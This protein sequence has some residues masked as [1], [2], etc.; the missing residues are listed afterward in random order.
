MTIFQ[1]FQIIQH[2]NIWVEKLVVALWNEF[3]KTR[4][5]DRVLEDTRTFSVFGDGRELISSFIEYSMNFVWPNPG[6]SKCRAVSENFI[7]LRL[8]A[9]ENQN[10]IA[11]IIFYWPN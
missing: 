2:V 10:F 1:L 6:A 4:L 9:I 7:V 11:D 3:P 5:I 8:V